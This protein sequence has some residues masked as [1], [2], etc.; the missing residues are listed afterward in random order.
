[1]RAV[2]IAG[3]KRSGK[4]TLLALVAETLESQGKRVAVVK[5]SSHP[6]EKG[7]TDAFWLMAPDR[8]VVNV[9]GGETA[10]FWSEPLSFE[11]IIAHLRADVLLLEGDGAPGSIPRILCHREDGEADDACVP[12]PGAVTVIATHGACAAEPGVPHFPEMDLKTAGAIA[13]LVLE[14]GATL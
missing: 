4:T 3:S 2:A 9:S 13:A 8:A 11:A 10:L 7:H 1:M 6:L 14:K 12:P 5:Y